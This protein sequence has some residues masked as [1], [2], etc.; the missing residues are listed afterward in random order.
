MHIIMKPKTGKHGF[1][2]DADGNN[3]IQDGDWFIPLYPH[4]VHKRNVQIL[5]VN[6]NH[7]KPQ[8][9]R[10][11]NTKNIEM[12]TECDLFSGG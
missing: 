10:H 12:K 6:N 7:S 9:T 8:S 5:V 2:V 1:Y 4:A 11:Y 3:Y